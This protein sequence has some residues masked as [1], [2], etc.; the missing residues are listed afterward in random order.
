MLYFFFISLAPNTI[1]SSKEKL[2]RCFTNDYLMYKTK[3][4]LELLT[5][6]NIERVYFVFLISYDGIWIKEKKTQTLCN[7]PASHTASG[8]AQRSLSPYQGEICFGIECS[9]KCLTY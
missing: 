9:L 2:K 7:K 1:P 8:S 4:L 3:G 6:N 5:H